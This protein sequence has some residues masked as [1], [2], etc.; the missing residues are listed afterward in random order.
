MTYSHPLFPSCSSFWIGTL[1]IFP[2]KARLH[3]INMFGRLHG[4]P[5]M[6]AAA[7]CL[8]R[9][10]PHHKRFYTQCLSVRVLKYLGFYLKWLLT[11]LPSNS[12]SSFGS[13]CMSSR[14]KREWQQLRALSPSAV[15]SLNK[16]R[17]HGSRQ[18]AI[19]RS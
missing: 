16:W 11:K 18:Q 15:H 19:I 9:A 14:M 4:H 3:Q 2:P 8:Q 1:I 12:E 5:L 7:V 6:S 10:C 17:Q 13:H